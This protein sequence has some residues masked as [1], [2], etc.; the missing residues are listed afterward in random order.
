MA[1]N[2]SEIPMVDYA[3]SK[4]PD[5]IPQ[6]SAQLRDALV[7]V[8]FFYLINHPIPPSLQ[9]DL[10]DQSRQLFELSSEKKNKNGMKI[11]KHFVGYVG[12]DESTTSNHKDHRESYTLG[13]ECS[14][15]SPDEPQYR[16]LRG[17]NAWPDKEDLPDF[18]HTMERYMTEVKSLADEFKLMVAQ[19]LDLETTE[20]LQLFDNKPFDRLMLAKYVPPPSTSADHAAKCSEAKEIQGKGA[21]KDASWLTFLL[22]GSPHGG[23]E[24][25]NAAGDWIP[26][27]PRPGAM[28][29]NVGMQ[30]EA[31]TDGVCSA[32]FHR[33]VTRPRDFLDHN[34]NDLGPR[35]SFALFHN[36]SL[37][38]RQEK[39]LNISPHIAALV[40]NDEVRRNARIFLRRLFQQ[41]CPGEGIFAT[42][43][44]VYQQ[45]TEKWYPDRLA[46]AQEPVAGPVSSSR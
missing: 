17:P 42:R 41:G 37:D 18:R 12:M 29:I 11:N 20:L 9:W 6:F 4:S 34:G 25:M 38:L 13:Y 19:A 3:L 2:F 15:P 40:T 16:N 43:L 8:G 36:I 39:C 30:L 44:K 14:P 1:V 33:V 26:V 46:E 10:K 23:L 31:M 28:I 21:H 27:P 45:V 22:P 24:A 32:A 35:F 7:K 5:T